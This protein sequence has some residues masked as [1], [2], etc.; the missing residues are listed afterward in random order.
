MKGRLSLPG[1]SMYVTK[2][3]KWHRGCFSFTFVLIFFCQ[4][5]FLSVLQIYLLLKFLWVILDVVSNSNI[6][7]SRTAGSFVNDELQRTWLRAS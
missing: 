3:A 1:W 6:H 5:L 7:K 4:V 2:R